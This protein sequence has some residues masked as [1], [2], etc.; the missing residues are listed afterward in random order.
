MFLDTIYQLEIDY[1]RVVAQGETIK[2][3]LSNGEILIG[4]YIS[5]DYTELAIERNDAEIWIEFEE[6][7]DIEIIKE[8]QSNE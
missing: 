6:I 4:T 5:S 7:D 3:F 2:V 1:E 8:G